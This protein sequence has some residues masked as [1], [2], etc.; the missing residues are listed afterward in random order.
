MSEGD[1]VT[2]VPNQPKTPQHSVRVSDELWAAAKRRAESENRSLSEVVRIALEAYVKG[3]G[4][5]F[6]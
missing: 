6:P 1:N 2:C 5:R 4:T 3:K